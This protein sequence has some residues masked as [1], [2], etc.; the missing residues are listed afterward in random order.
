MNSKQVI[1]VMFLLTLTSISSIAYV[2]YVSASPDN[3]VPP[4]A[5]KSRWSDGFETYTCDAFPVPPWFLRFS[6]AGSAFQRVDCNVSKQGSQSLHLLGMDVV[7]T[8]VRFSA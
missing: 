7:V 5:S 8:G 2:S 6:G 1:A 3:D 4:P